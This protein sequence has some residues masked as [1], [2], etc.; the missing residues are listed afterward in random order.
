MPDGEDVAGFINLAVAELCGLNNP[1]KVRI[2]DFGCGRGSLVNILNAKGYK[3]FGCDIKAFWLE[4]NTEDSES[5]RQIK[6]PY[7][8][9]FSDD[10]FDVVVSISVLEHAKNPEE[11]FLEIKRVLKPNGVAMHLFGSKWYLP[12][13]PH[14]YVPLVNF[15]WPQCPMWWFKAW[16]ILGIRNEYQKNLSWRQTA[17][18][19]YQYSL[20]GL[21]YYSNK[22]YR[23]LSMDIFGNFQNPMVFYVK[24]SGG[25]V[26]KLSRQF[27][28]LRF[29]GWI[30]SIFRMNFILMRK[31]I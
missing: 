19:N 23:K 21:V 13:E 20:E 27:P 24:N 2:L 11:I 31:I 4:T 15:F 7:R 17:L 9:P 25:G 8:L 3:A 10:F 12:S 30:S 1:K 18:L 22:Y 14:I 28:F 29:W 6:F 26:S 5:L 16:A